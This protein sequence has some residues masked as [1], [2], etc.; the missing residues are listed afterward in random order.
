MKGFRLTSRVCAAATAGIGFKSAETESNNDN[1]RSFSSAWYPA[2][3]PVEDRFAHDE[4][5]A[6]GGWR[7]FS[8]HDG[9]GGF[10]VAEF[11]HKTLIPSVRKQYESQKTYVS[12]FTERQREKRLDSMES[13]QAVL[14]AAFAEVEREYFRKVSDA[15]PLGFGEL[16]KVGSCVLLA[17]HKGNQLVLA[18]CGDCRAVLGTACTQGADGDAR[19]KHFATRLTHDHNSR[20]PLEA[21]RLVRAHPGEPDIIVCKSDHACYVKGRLQLTRALGDGYLK[22]AELNAPANQHRSW[23][24]HIPQPYS[25]PYVISEPEVTR[26]RLQQQDAFVVMATDGLWDEMSDQE[27]VSVVSRC[28][29]E[30]RRGD[31]AGAL[32]EEALR[33]AAFSAGISVSELKA[34]PAGNRRRSIHDDTT[35]V[36]VWLCKDVEKH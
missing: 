17:M 18:N 32:V 9:H 19:K 23:G 16:A 26:V 12:Y 21:L 33:R 20:V 31:A 10:Q 27:A 4:A 30:G 8:V 29:A 14:Q 3:H 15:F 13:I 35:A 7:I 5:G 34:L 2:N 22:Y 36:V 25:P 28:A 24:R 11:S 6:G 1:A